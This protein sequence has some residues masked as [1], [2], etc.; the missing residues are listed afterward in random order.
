MSEYFVG[1]PGTG[2]VEDP[3]EPPLPGAAPDGASPAPEAPTGPRHV[4]FGMPFNGVVPLWHDGTD[5][6]WYRPTDGTDLAHVLGLG[7]VE[8]EPGPSPT[9]TGWAEHVETGTLLPAQ[10]GEEGPVLLLR[11]ASPSGRRA[12]NDPG[13][14]ARVP[15]SLPL[16]VQEAMGDTA[17]DFDITGF[18]VHVARLMLRAARDGAILLFTLR[19]PRDPEAHHLLSVPS[20]VDA[21]SVMR[22]HLGTLLDVDTPSWAEA[23]HQDGMTLLDLEVPYST[24][25]SRAGGEEGLDVERLV[26]MA[27]PV[28][29]AVLAPGFPFALGCSFILPE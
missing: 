8:T 7:H 17:A 13:D 20:E 4:R 12:V 28:V 2:D 10:D 25:V 27:Q 26:A 24:L 9:P 21:D 22:F 29:D 19:A 6:E 16:T 5:I 1:R 18:S 11:A 3:M 23:T 15:L 14:G